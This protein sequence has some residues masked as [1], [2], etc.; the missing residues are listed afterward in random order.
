VLQ[1]A[2][3]EFT[4]SE[5]R[6]DADSA[7]LTD[8]PGPET[9]DTSSGDTATP[10]DSAGDATSEAMP[11]ATTEIGPPICAV[12]EY[13]CVEK[14]RQKCSADRT[15]WVDVE[16]CSV[17]CQASGCTTAVEI[18][19]GGGTSCAR[20]SD[21]SVWCWGVGEEGQIGD[22]FRML[23]TRPT[24]I[25][26]LPKAAAALAAGDRHMCALLVD[27]HAY[28][29]GAN[30]AGQLGDGT[31]ATRDLPVP[32]VG[33][34]DALQI[35]GGSQYTCVRRSTRVMSCWGGNSN[36][37]LGDGTNT[38]RLAPVDVVGLGPDGVKDLAGG[39]LHT[40]AV[41]TD[42]A[43]VC[44]GAGNA[45]QLGD[46]AGSNRLSPGPAAIASGTIDV[47]VGW[48]H[49]C[50][51]LADRTVSCWGAGSLGELGDGRREASLKPVPVFGI[52][53]AV[54]ISTGNR[55]TC[56]RLSDNTLR[57]WGDNSHGQAGK[58]TAS[59][60]EDV[61]VQ[62]V[63]ITDAA[64]VAVSG[65]RFACARLASGTVK[66]WGQGDGVLGDGTTSP[67]LRPVEV[68]W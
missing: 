13:R 29:W 36:G 42:G 62:V 22:G 67:S 53:T 8:A 64:E 16:T 56:V 54:S 47:S 38:L 43:T 4:P 65:G 6:G 17:M 10:F 19:V 26:A 46:G 66:C 27:R 48:E 59:A 50:S 15:R 23:R 18:A 5:P 52:T 63:D 34:E 55:T 11:D 1:L 14:Q 58:G 12:D 37:M 45:G 30:E 33:V 61:P 2:C 25:V 31:K 9:S 24:R 39:T 40:C 7:A 51:V 3:A 35:V 20:M 32:V 68:K 44:W 41:T 49:S 57:C 28:C 21:G 60:I